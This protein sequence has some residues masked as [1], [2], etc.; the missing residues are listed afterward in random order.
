MHQINYSDK[1]VINIFPQNL[2]KTSLFILPERQW[3]QLTHETTGEQVTLVASSK[4][5]KEIAR[6]DAQMRSR[7]WSHIEFIILDV[8]QMISYSI[9]VWKIDS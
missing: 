9:R 5:G 4:S 7:Y 6:Q 2:E 3:V 8:V 1:S